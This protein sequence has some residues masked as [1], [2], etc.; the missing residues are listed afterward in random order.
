MT[1]HLLDAS[2]LIALSVTGHEHNQVA[3]RAVAAL[4][5]VVLCPVVEGA[6]VRTLLRLGESAST[7]VMHL[8]LLH[9]MPGWHRVADD[10]SYR[11][12][13]LSWVIGHRQ[14]TDAYLLSLAHHHGLT[15]LTLDSALAARE[16]AELIR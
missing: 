14:V 12:A 1:G 13:D 3:R 9:A 7:C 5:R 16:G 10:L 6:L 8:G 2:V 11:D 15:L 4:P